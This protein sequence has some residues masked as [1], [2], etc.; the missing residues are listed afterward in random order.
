MGFDNYSHVA[1]VAMKFE[2]LKDMAEM[3]GC[4]RYSFS[5]VMIK[6]VLPTA[7]TASV[8][9]GTDHMMNGD[10]QMN[11]NHR[12]III[13]KYCVVSNDDQLINEKLT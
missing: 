7:A 2:L 11:G 10:G 8:L 4:C 3:V 5:I 1:I 6:W 13:R 9:P 12:A